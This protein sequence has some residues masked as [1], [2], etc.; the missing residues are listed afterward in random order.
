MT[1][2]NV[3]FV[4]KKLGSLVPDAGL[5]TVEWCDLILC[6]SRLIRKECQQQDWKEGSHKGECAAFKAVRGWNSFPW[7]RFDGEHLMT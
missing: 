5:S 7:D 3:L 2:R 6:G 4:G 1:V